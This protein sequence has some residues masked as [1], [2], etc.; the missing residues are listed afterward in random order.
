MPFKSIDWYTELAEAIEF[1]PPPGLRLTR[2][3]DDKTI[4]GMLAEGE[5]D[6]LIHP[7]LID[8]IKNKDPRVGRLFPNYKEEEIAFYKRTKIFPDHACRR[9][10]ARH[11]RSPSLG[12]DQSLSRL[13]RRQG[14]PR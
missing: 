1:T 6:A 2:I 12:S 10:E 9:A 4:D 7:D 13:Q 14:L 11:R 5:I 3:P 8:P